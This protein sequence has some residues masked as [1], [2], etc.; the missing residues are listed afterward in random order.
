MAEK[1]SGQK[2][3]WRGPE[4]TVDHIRKSKLNSSFERTHFDPGLKDIYRWYSERY[5]PT[6]QEK[7]SFCER[8]SERKKIKN[9]T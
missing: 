3:V 9:Q 6:V 2:L 4:M 5:G 1:V 8:E 7:I